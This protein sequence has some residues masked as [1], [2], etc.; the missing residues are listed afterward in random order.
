MEFLNLNYYLKQFYRYKQ[1]LYQNYYYGKVFLIN[2]NHNNI[3]HLYKGYLY[4]FIF[5][6]VNVFQSF[7]WS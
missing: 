4:K 5:F 1:K 6:C 7:F 3:V 2:I